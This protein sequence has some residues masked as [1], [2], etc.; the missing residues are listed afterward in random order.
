M[1]KLVELNF[2]YILKSALI[3]NNK[4]SGLNKSIFNYIIVVL[5]LIGSLFAFTIPV[6]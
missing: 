3:R 4:C 5:I 1:V 6:Y 2:F